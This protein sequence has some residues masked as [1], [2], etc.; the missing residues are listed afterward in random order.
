M[1]T[2]I[3]LILSLSIAIVV[4]V[5]CNNSTEIEKPIEP[6]VSLQIGDM[7]QI[8]NTEEGYYKQEEVIDTVR[9]SDGIKAFTIKIS[10]SSSNGLLTG[11]VYD[12]ISDNYLLQT[13]LDTTAS[14]TGNKYEESILAKVY[15]KDGDNYMKIYGVTDSVNAQV[16]IKI[17]DSLATPCGTFKNVAE[18]KMKN[19]YDLYYYYAPGVGY[20]GSMAIIDGVRH[21]LFIT[22]KVINGKV[23]G[24]YKKLPDSQIIN[25]SKSLMWNNITKMLNRN[26]F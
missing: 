8:Y 26:C 11:K 12:L 18:Y 1:K 22:Y 5:S 9:R 10:M 20:I 4:F 6:Y 13:Q 7:W 21:D 3:F 16:N 2:K 17:K 15:P 19:P 25:Q 14:Y 23:L 24:K